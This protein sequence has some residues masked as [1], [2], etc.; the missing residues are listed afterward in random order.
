MYKKSNLVYESVIKIKKAASEDSEKRSHF[1]VLSRQDKILDDVAKSSESI[2]SFVKEEKDVL[3][4]KET[5]AFTEMVRKLRSQ[6]NSS[7]INSNSGIVISPRM[8]TTYPPGETVKLTIYLP[9]KFAKDK[10]VFTCD[11]T[12]SVEHI[13]TNEKTRKREHV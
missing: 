9:D 11:L 6:L 5:V 7:D 2:L 4:D 1:K 3:S 13:I 10:I 8:E 12:S